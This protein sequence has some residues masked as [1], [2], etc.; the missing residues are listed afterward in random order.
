MVLD[1]NW[2]I[3]VEFQIKGLTMKIITKFLLTFMLLVSTAITLNGAVAPAAGATEVIINIRDGDVSING[4]NVIYKKSTTTNLLDVLL[5][6]T[7]AGD[8]KPNDN[9]N[10]QSMIDNI[11][12]G[13]STYK[14]IGT[15]VITLTGT[16]TGAKFYGKLNNDRTLNSILTV[17]P[18]SGYT[19]GNVVS[20]TDSATG[21]VVP[22]TTGV[23]LD[24]QV[25]FGDGGGKFW[26]V[27]GSYFSSLVVAIMIVMLAFVFLSL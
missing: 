9:N 7:N 14:F 11:I 19:P 21:K 27:G 8:S 4:G 12:I 26:D 23:V 1:I 15:P 3:V 18:G 17:S 16:G 22:I 6:H 25:K 2:R 10:N 13:K 5:S 20:I 24:R